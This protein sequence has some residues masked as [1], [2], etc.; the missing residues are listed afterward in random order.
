MQLEENLGAEE[1]NLTK[2]SECIVETCKVEVNETNYQILE[3]ELEE[4]NLDHL[5]KDVQVKAKE[6]LWRKRKAFVS[7]DGEIGEATGLSMKINTTD[8]V[9][10]QKNY[11]KIPKPLIEE[12]KEHV[13]DLLN[14][15]WIK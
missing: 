9:P 6:M 4:M 1:T 12:V 14:R 2:K 13:C 11:Y 3:K 5:E 8:E 7:D 10:V 15:G